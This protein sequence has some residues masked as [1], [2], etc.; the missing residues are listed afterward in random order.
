MILRFVRQSRVPAAD[1]VLID[2]VEKLDSGLA[3][4]SR[5]CV[6]VA[7]ALFPEEVEVVEA[8]LEAG[9]IAKYSRRHAELAM[10]SQRAE[11]QNSETVVL[12][13]R[14]RH[15]ENSLFTPLEVQASNVEVAAQWIRE[16]ETV[17]ESPRSVLLP[18]VRH[19]TVAELVG[20]VS[21][22]VFAVLADVDRDVCDERVGICV[23][24]AELV[25]ANA[26]IGGKVK[27]I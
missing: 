10:R 16:E 27:D 20:E 22:S 4:D 2:Q 13:R 9:G 19:E 23:F 12:D 18:R 7:G 26:T 3:H 8:L 14:E 17:S 5:R 21:V 1:G 6:S 15:A 24:W 11:V 25:T